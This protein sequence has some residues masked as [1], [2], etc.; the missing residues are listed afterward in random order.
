M[1][2]KFIIAIYFCILSILKISAQFLNT[3]PQDIEFN[4]GRHNSNGCRLG[5][6]LPDDVWE[7]SSTLNG[8]YLPA[9]KVPTISAWSFQSPAC[10]YAF[11]WIGSNFN[12]YPNDP[13][14]HGC[15]INSTIQQYY[16]VTFNLPVNP[17]LVLSW[18]IAADD[19]V[20]GIYINNNL[21][22]FTIPPGPHRSVPFS[23]LWCTGWVQGANTIKIRVRSSGVQSPDNWAG[24]QVISWTPPPPMTTVGSPTACG[25]SSTKIFTIT[26]APSGT[27]SYSWSL[28]AWNGSS[29]SPTINPTFGTNSVVL[30]TYAMSPA[31]CV[32]ASTLAVIVKSPTVS[33][34]SSTNFICPGN[35]SILTASGAVTY[36]WNQP[37]VSVASSTDNPI[38]VTPTIGTVY[39]VT[40]WGV[41]GCT[42]TANYS[43]NML[44]LPNLTI[45]SQPSV[46]CAGGVNT[47]T[48]TGALNYNWQP[49]GPLTS[50]TTVTPPTGI[51][52][53][54]V[55]GQSANGC[56]NTA[57]VTLTP[58]VTIPLSTAANVTICADINPCATLSTVTSFTSPVTY[59]WF[60][61]WLPVPG[62]Q[63]TLSICPPLTTTYVVTASSNFGCSST[64]NIAVQVQNCCPPTP[65]NA[66]FA[67]PTSSYCNVS[68]T[69][70][71]QYATVPGTF[72]GPGI[73][74]NNGQYDFN[75]SGALGAGGYVIVFTFTTASAPQGCI[76][77][78]NQIITNL[79]PL[80]IFGFGAERCGYSPVATTA[81]AYVNQGGYTYYWQ[82]GGVFGATI[83]VTPT[84]TTVYTVTALKGTCISTAAVTMSVNYNCC[85]QTSVATI[86]TNTLLTAGTA[87][88]VLSGPIMINQSMTIT[89]NGSFIFKAGDFIMGMGV[90][91]TL[92]PGVTLI[93]EDAHLYNCENYMWD[94]II[95]KNG[96]T[97]V[98]Y[99][100]TLGLSTLIEDATTA[101]SV[102][103]IA[104]GHTNPL[105]NLD[106]VIFNRNWTS[107]S[108]TNSSLTSI[109]LLIKSCVFTN[110]DLP[111]STLFWPSSSSNP[112]GLR[113]ASAAATASS[114][115]APFISS[116]YTSIPITSSSPIAIWIENIGNIA[117]GF[118]D[119]GINLTAW[120]MPFATEFNLFD[121]MY[122]GIQITNASMTTYNNTFQNMVSSGISQTVTTTMNARLSLT[123]PSL[124]TGNRFW[125]FDGAIFAGNVFEFD[126]ENAI[127]RKGGRA[128][129]VSSSRFDK[130]NIRNNTFVNLGL[131]IE[132]GFQS[133]PYNIPYHV[134]GSNTGIYAGS[135][136][137][138]GNYFSPTI[139]NVPFTNAGLGTGIFIGGSSNIWHIPSL[140]QGS[141]LQPYFIQ[142]NIIE[143]AQFGIELQDMTAYPLGIINNTI[144]IED[145]SPV[146]SPPSVKRGIWM[147]YTLGH[148]TIRNNLIT[149]VGGNTSNNPIQLIFSNDN[150]LPV[151]TCNTVVG[152]YEGFF[153]AGNNV[154]TWSGNVMQNNVIG[155]H[156]FG[157]ILPAPLNY[158]LYTDIGPQ[159]SA[160]IPAGNQWIGNFTLHTMIDF[161]S[162]ALANSMYV[163]S[164]NLSEVPVN[165][166]GSNG[167][168]TYSNNISNPALSSIIYTNGTYNCPQT[169]LILRLANAEMNSDEESVGEEGNI[170]F[171][172]NPTSGKLIISGT[173]ESERLQVRLLDMTG[174]T[175]YLK[176]LI[177]SNYKCNI[178][179]DF[180]QGIYMINISD[181]NNNKLT[182]KLIINK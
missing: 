127:F 135:L 50:V 176:T 157:Y 119:A 27:T 171:Y 109:P 34:T 137:I 2:G 67:L 101:I 86:I 52:T 108:L 88:S 4:T 21:I 8:T 124:S 10:S 168:N 85:P 93:L 148:K 23:F 134:N 155:M 113:Y 62:N 60:D 100:G 80:P 70:L 177:T 74:F 117:G 151:I 123:S 165:N 18:Q 121:N 68:F 24:L 95:V 178:D 38:V 120:A 56:T 66:L 167:A 130:Y 48:A 5:A 91:I 37:A 78:L 152:G 1:K 150:Y 175:I 131:G 153:F 111:S 164:S 166:G 58:G 161:P 26:Q 125:D 59:S 179:L 6:M 45:T 106:G 172:P 83:A 73:T 35:R 81:S 94:G 65:T 163:N 147:K 173:E 49:V 12:C 112:G 132:L 181:G 55:I 105:L 146:G 20:L 182:R 162:D 15:N 169:N 110:R 72:S 77:Q 104:S 30:N 144:Q 92:D 133:G 3:P 129:Y 17:V 7:V 156:L 51:N 87:T 149:A 47:L 42:N 116:S 13:A 180:E 9:I 31:G 136:D 114:M 170:G 28:P 140:S 39:S 44:P 96:A 61:F 154:G 138:S 174:K 14:N 158:T 142:N 40:G 29:T 53:Y 11:A 118:P 143:K 98:S 54:T 75:V 69:N 71:A 102:D 41:A 32:G 46:V 90:T 57:V 84:V 76:Y 128:I 19:E 97:V 115:I 79:S 139:N 141:V 160:G 103:N 126:I 64:T 107:I 159:G 89:G 22:P 25:N 43:V 36:S 99:P 82:P 63:S 33:V 145:N 16:K 122:N